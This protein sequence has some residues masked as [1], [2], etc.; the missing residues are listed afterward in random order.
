M[1]SV[2]VPTYRKE[3]RLRLMLT[4]LLRSS[5]EIRSEL[6]IIVVD[7]GNQHDLQPIVAQALA[8]ESPTTVQVVKGP[9]R[10]RSVARNLGAKYASNDRILFLDDDVLVARGALEAHLAYAADHC[11]QFVRGTILNFPWLVAFEDPEL[12][13]LTDRAIR[14]LGV[15][16]GAER[17]ALQQRTITLDKSG[18]VDSHLIPYLKISRFERDLHEW[19]FA[20]PVEESGRWIGATGAHLSVDRTWFQKLGGFDELMG[21]EWGAE[22]L[23][24]GYRAEKMGIPIVHAQNAIVYHMDHDSCDRQSEHQGAFEY[25]ARKHED[26]NLLK[27]LAYFSHECSLSEAMTQ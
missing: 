24:F 2:V 3:A 6:E 7:D 25:F 17:V 5:L 10:G 27:I 14:S 12:G 20:R 1:L 8:G 13:T 22:D 19:L 11:S 15:K 4:C 9:H 26:V 23:E 21:L 16:P 18:N